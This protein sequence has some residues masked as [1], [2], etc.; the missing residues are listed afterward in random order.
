M[1][2][3][4]ITKIVTDRAMSYFVWE[5]SSR[6]IKSTRILVSN[7]FKYFKNIFKN[8]FNSFQKFKIK[9][10]KNN[11]IFHLKKFTGIY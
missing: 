11:S 7:D 9:F 2:S 10:Y 3:K 8:N 1:W 4:S 5:E 6:D